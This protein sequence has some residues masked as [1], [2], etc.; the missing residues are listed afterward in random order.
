MLY[1]TSSSSRSSNICRTF[2]LQ[3][4][5]RLELET[6]E[7]KWLQKL[8]EA[9]RRETE[10]REKVRDVELQEEQWGKKIKEEKIREDEWKSRVEEA[11]QRGTEQ[12][13]E[14]TIVEI[15]EYREQVLCFT[16]VLFDITYACVFAYASDILQYILVK[17]N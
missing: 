2:N 1:C 13:K 8:E 3:A 9:E 7:A 5:L 17:S 16:F 10:L 11:L 4:V 14:R 15:E 12:E 6:Q